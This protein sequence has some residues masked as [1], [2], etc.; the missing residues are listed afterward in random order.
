MVH[1]VLIVGAGLAGLCCARRTHQA[2]LR[3]LVLET[4]DGVGGRVRTDRVDGFR[5]DRGFQVFLTAY[6][7]AKKSLDYQAL[8]LRSFQPG[9]L[10]RQGG[11]FHRL[12]DPWRRPLQEL[13]S[14]FTPVGSYLDKARVGRLHS[15]VLRGSLEDCFNEP[16]STTLQAL[17]GAG[18]SH[19]M[20]DRF[21]RPFLSGI[22]LE[23]DLQTSSRMFRF[24]FRMFSSGDACLPAEGMEAIPRQLAAGLPADSV[25]L[26]ARAVRVEAGLVHLAS[27]EVLRTRAVVVAV[28]G[29]AAADLLGEKL[30]AAA[31]GVTCLYF[32]ADQPPVE[33]PILVLNGEGQGPV[34]NLCVPSFVSPAYAPQG[35]HLVSATVLGIP[36]QDDARLEADVPDHLAGWYG[37]AVH[38]WRHLRT[39]RI[40][41]AL[42]RQIPPALS[43]PERPVR[44]QPGV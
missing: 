25:R 44:W 27:G 39:Y 41:F 40:P 5:L 1:D 3:P 14:L 18:F 20:I 15:Q 43:V 35:Q 28:E 34:N 37:P 17:Q 9:A 42:P 8:D 33:E 7:E 32:A 2:G 11:A 26:G 12:T 38:G 16:E 13:R 24:V 19:S 23:P 29:A 10:V 22:F 6:P 36:K 4:S 30:S 21:F 31:Q